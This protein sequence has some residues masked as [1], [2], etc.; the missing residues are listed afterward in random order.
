MS[1]FTSPREKRLWLYAF[2]VVSV[3]FSTLFIGNPLLKLLE[4]QDIQAVLFVL[5][6]LL[7]G[8]TIITHALRLQPSG[9]E[10]TIWLGMMAIFLM[11]FLRLGLPERSHL[12]EYGVL[13]I[14]IHL[15]LL[16][17]NTKEQPH[18]LPALFAFLITFVIG[19]M[20][21][22]IQLFI[23]NRV[24]D[25]EDIIFNGFAALFAIGGNVILDYSRR[26]KKE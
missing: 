9:I 18:F 21:E 24:F 25:S 13:A 15:A 1:L 23:P 3:I 12:I 7:V 26:R 10:L 22:G 4:N 19:V 17:R 14:F 8:V 5:G 20:D 16:E 2:I 6:M 11:V